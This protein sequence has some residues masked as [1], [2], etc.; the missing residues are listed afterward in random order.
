MGCGG[1]ITKKGPIAEILQKL[2]ENYELIK[3]QC[4]NEKLELEKKGIILLRHAALEKVKDNPEQMM[5]VVKEFNKT[6]LDMDNKLIANENERMKLLYKLG[7]DLSKELQDKMV[8]EL[9]EKISKAPSMTIQVLKKQLSEIT[10][11]SPQEFLQSDFGKPLKEA[12]EKK[13]LNKAYMDGYKETL[14]AQRKERRFKERGEF[15]IN[16]NEFPDEEIFDDDKEGETFFEKLMRG[17]I[18]V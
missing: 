17:A 4:N 1:S 5:I 6:E 14:K 13:G 7:M 9:E 2:D 8:K 10:R 3:K 15:N 16:V 12:L 18:Q 11:F